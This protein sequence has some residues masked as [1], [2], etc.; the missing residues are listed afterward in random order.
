M[1][2]QIDA[3]WLKWGALN[4][5]TLGYGGLIGGY[6]NMMEFP[7]VRKV[8]INTGFSFGN[9]GT[10]LFMSNMKDFSRGGTLFGLRGTYTLSEAI[11]LKFGINFVTDMN[12]FWL[13]GFDGDSYPDMFDDYPED[14][15]YW[16]D[17][18]GDGIPDKD[19][20]SKAPSGGWDIDGDGDNILD[21]QDNDLT[22]KPTPFSIKVTL[23]L[24]KVFHWM[25]VTH[26]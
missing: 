15:D 10:E 1:G 17:T 20:G 13:K 6:S 21:T 8:G 3:F 14:K 24:L 4:N 12:Q 5:V 18:D 22:L 25:L 23:H 2:C 9:F 19:G 7:T 16:N 26:C 11:P